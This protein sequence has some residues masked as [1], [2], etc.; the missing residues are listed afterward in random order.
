ML[1]KYL[2][3][4]LFLSSLRVNRLK[5]ADLSTWHESLHL[6]LTFGRIYFLSK[7][8]TGSKIHQFSDIY[9]IYEKSEKKQQTNILK[10]LEK[11][12]F[13]TN[14]DS[15]QNDF[16]TFCVLR[17][18]F[19]FGRCVFILLSLCTRTPLYMCVV[20]A[21]FPVHSCWCNT[22]NSLI[23]VRVESVTEQ[24]PR[25]PTYNTTSHRS[26][27]QGLHHFHHIT[28]LWFWFPSAIRVYQSIR[29]DCT[30]H[31]KNSQNDRYPQQ[32]PNTEPAG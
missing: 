18:T 23:I 22:Y 25:P 27:L 31:Y 7:Q 24:D 2:G 17:T 20:F 19:R 11:L 26:L 32:L 8:I 10:I 29:V 14:W 13:T 12:S 9:K 3:W 28:V 5:V 6:H 1:I 30:D 15:Q 21:A 16:F 4:V